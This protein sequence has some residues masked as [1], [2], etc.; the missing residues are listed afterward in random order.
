MKSWPRFMAT[1]PSLLGS[2]V[3][4]TRPEQQTQFISEQ[5]T[6]LGAKVISIG[7]IDIMP[8][9]ASFWPKLALE[10]QDMIVFVSRNAVMCFIAGFSDRLPATTRL[11]A[12]G[13][14]TARCMVEQGLRVD[15]QAPAPAGS[16]S[17]LAMAEMQAVEGL[18]VTIVRGETGRELIADTLSA[19]G[20]KIQYLEVYRRSLP[21]YSATEI[22]Q[23]QSADIIVVMSAAGLENVCQL[24]NN[25]TIKEKRLV[26]V[27]ER[28]RQFAQGL[29][30]QCIAVTDDVSDTAVVHQVIEIGQNNGE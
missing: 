9:E 1:N 12:V 18:R 26:V 3:L 4:V 2:T 25:D 8:I 19:R 14:A 20:A 23:A 21:Q 17:L 22:A 15:I 28:I 27:S 5:L 29:G 10:S 6:Q 30:F 16:E 13:A 11:V 7:V 24:L